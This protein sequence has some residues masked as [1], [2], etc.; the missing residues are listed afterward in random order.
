[1]AENVKCPKWHKDNTEIGIGL[2]AKAKGKTGKEER[3]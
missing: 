2:H 3:R 1:M